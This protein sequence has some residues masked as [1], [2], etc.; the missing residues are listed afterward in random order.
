MFGVQAE[1]LQGVGLRVVTRWALSGERIAEII[2]CSSD[3]VASLRQVVEAQTGALGRCRLLLGGRVLRS[4]ESLLD[5]GV[6]DGSVVLVVR[7]LITTWPKTTRVEL[8]LPRCR[9][10]LTHDLLLRDVV[11]DDADGGGGGG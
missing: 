1:A 4:R 5:V 3:T 7:V 6:G 2:C 10:L 8:F 9:L 11:A